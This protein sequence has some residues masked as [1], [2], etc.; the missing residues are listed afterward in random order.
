[1][2]N[3]QSSEREQEQFLGKIQELVAT[4]KENGSKVTEQELKSA[5]TDMNLGANQ[6]EQVRV[7]LRGSGVVID[8]SAGSTVP[9]EERITQEEHNY[10]E[11]YTSLINSIE[12]PS[13]SVLDAVKLSA[14]AGEKSAQKELIEFSLGKVIEISHLYAGQGVFVEDL[15]GA[16]NEALTIGVTLLGPLEHPQEVDGFLGKRIMDAMEDLI[17]EAIDAHAVE[18]EVE[19]RVNLVADKARELASELGRK[20]TP[21]ELAA[22]GD[23]TLAQIQEAVRLSGNKIEEIE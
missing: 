23:V 7:F 2:N 9:I 1:M 8:A 17:A 16:G 21:A 20:V 11:E 15:I 22:E 18:K 6:M 19:N 14:M 13:E 12:L 4:A 5:F 3:Q 10:L